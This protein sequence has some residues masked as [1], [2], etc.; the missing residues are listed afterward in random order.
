MLH[1]DLEKHVLFPQRPQ[2]AG[3]LQPRAS[4]I[5]SGGGEG[6]VDGVV[7]TDRAPKPIGPYSQARVVG[8]LLFVSGQIGI[9]PATG[10]LVEGGFREQA[11]QALENLRSI[12][13]AAG[14]SMEDV[15]L[16]VAFLRDM[17][18]YKEF[19]EIYAQHFKVYPARA[20]VEVSNLPA[21]A[22]VEIMAIAARRGAP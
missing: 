19:N 11:R 8:N 2:A 15:V 12:V 5:R 18:Y 6:A 13:E 22:L 17:T 16:V 20:V 3:A 14:F 10:K 7:F 1:E 9:D 4:F 21:G